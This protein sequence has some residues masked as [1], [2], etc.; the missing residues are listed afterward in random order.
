MI[1]D[2]VLE[3]RAEAQ[4]ANAVHVWESMVA[5]KQVKTRPY[6]TREE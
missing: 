5:W 6:D 3:S 4:R 2:G 1:G